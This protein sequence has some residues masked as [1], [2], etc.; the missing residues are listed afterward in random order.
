MRPV[1]RLMDRIQAV[2]CPPETGDQTGSYIRGPRAVV[3]NKS[4]GRSKLADLEAVSSTEAE[5]LLR[6]DPVSEEDIREALLSTKPSSDF[7]Q[8]EK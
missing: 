5:N 6:Q 7:G 4:N 1:R 3:N 8:F 2:P